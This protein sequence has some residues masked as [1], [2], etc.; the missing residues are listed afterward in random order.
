MPLI[1]C[2]LKRAEPIVV[3]IANER[4][5]F[6]DDGSGR[7]V[8]EVWIESHVESFLAVPHLYRQVE[9]VA[10][11]LAPS[12]TAKPPTKPAAKGKAK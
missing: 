3:P 2:T 11:P 12:E 1:E 8:A 7:L 4:Y 5:E 10:S 6:L 9:A